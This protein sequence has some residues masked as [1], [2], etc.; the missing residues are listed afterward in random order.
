MIDDE[1]IRISSSLVRHLIST[2]FPN[3]RNLPIRRVDADGWDNSTFRLGD[4]LKVRLPAS[5]QYV[6]QVAKEYRWLPRLAPLLPIAVPMPVALGAPADTYPW[7]WAVYRWL[8]GETASPERIDDQHKFATDL[9]QFLRAL[10]RIDAVDGP[11]PGPHSFYRGGPLSIYNTDTRQSLAVLRG[12]I[13]ADEAVAVWEAA[14]AA[15]WHGPTVWVHGDMAAA[16]LIVKNGRLTGVIDFGCCAVGD[17]ACDLIQLAQAM[18]D[19]VTTDGPGL[20]KFAMANSGNTAFE[21]LS[22]DLEMGGSAVSRVETT[23]AVATYEWNKFT[24]QTT[25]QE[26]QQ[27]ATA[28]LNYAGNAAL[29][30]TPVAQAIVSQNIVAAEVTGSKTDALLNNAMAA[31]ESGHSY[32]ETTDM[33][34]IE[35]LS[36]S[37]LLPSSLVRLANVA[38][39]AQ[40]LYQVA[41]NSLSNFFSCG[42]HYYCVN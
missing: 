16:N 36:T 8:E 28:G 35:Y 42:D 23:V 15:P 10:Q 9:A 38:M 11:L 13:D 37:S 30:G 41:A 17:P 6:P 2:Q 5:A 34:N 31:V 22:Q 1:R 33:K 39:S 3:W 20:V 25:A 19:S 14:L 32:D 7:P 4:N 18:H 26:D 40:K 21:A 27:A 29:Q 24:G 12:E